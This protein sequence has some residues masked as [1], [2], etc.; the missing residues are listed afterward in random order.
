MIIITIIIS[1]PIFAGGINGEKNEAHQHYLQ[2]LCQYFT[3]GIKTLIL[4]HKKITEAEEIKQCCHVVKVSTN[5]N[6]S[7]PAAAKTKSK[8]K[9]IEEEN[10]FRYLVLMTVKSAHF[11]YI[12]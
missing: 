9:Q 4:N 11:L 12:I 3:E 10:S 6:S 1:Y 7:V 8:A 2:D 5:T